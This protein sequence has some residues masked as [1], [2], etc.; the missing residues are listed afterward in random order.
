M[1][2]P[3][4]DIL[5]GDDSLDKL[6][7]DVE[8]SI[9]LAQEREDALDRQYHADAWIEWAIA[10]GFAVAAVVA[11]VLGAYLKGAP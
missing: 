3:G 6:I 1:T 9:R 8:R 7:D 2:T 10:L 4:R 11:C 5:T